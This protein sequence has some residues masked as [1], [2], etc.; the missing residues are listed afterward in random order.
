MFTTKVRIYQCSVYICNVLSA[1][2]KRPK[3]PPIVAAF[4]HCTT[5]LSFLLHNNSKNIHRQTN[6]V[7]Q[8]VI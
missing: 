6:N 1:A 7:Q 4:M 8:N 3:K 5:H 2:P